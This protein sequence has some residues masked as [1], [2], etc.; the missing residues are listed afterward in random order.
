M[1]N[2]L[3]RLS[4]TNRKIKKEVKMEILEES[5]K[6]EKTITFECSCGCKF[7]AL[8]GET[9]PIPTYG[10]RDE[11]T[12]TNYYIRCPRCKAVLKKWTN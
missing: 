5:G 11:R 8:E 2:C 6:K 4:T 10:Q 7:R 1:I 3:F 9:I 12:G